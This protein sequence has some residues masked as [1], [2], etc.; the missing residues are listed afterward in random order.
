M[1]G[2]KCDQSPTW[3]LGDGMR[4]IKKESFMETAKKHEQL[5]EILAKIIATE[6]KELGEN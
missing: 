4:S 3:N 2:I 5:K 6:E 1:A